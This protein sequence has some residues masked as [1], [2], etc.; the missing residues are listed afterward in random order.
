M[1][2]T[3]W[4][5]ALTMLSACGWHLRGVTPLPKEYRVLF[6]QSQGGSSFDQQLKLQLEFNN[7][8]LTETAEDAPAILQVDSVE[9]ERRTLSVSSTGQVSEFELN[10]RLNARLLHLTRDSELNIQVK[11]RRSF[12]NDT[13]NVVG[14]AGEETKQKSELEKEL[15][16]K[17]MRRLQRASTN[18]DIKPLLQPDDTSSATSNVPATGQL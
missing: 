10:G 9:I 7:V 18:P 5:L 6:L 11:A 4:I 8:L 2:T 12:T 14:T 17:L 16:R 1:R 15:V 13:N 3:V